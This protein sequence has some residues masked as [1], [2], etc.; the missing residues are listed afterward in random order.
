MSRPPQPGGQGAR[1]AR[2]DTNR[3]REARPFSGAPDVMTGDTTVFCV[4]RG[5]SH[6]PTVCH[7]H[8]SSHNRLP[9]SDDGRVRP[10]LSLSGQVSVGAKHRATPVLCSVVGRSRPRWW[11][12]VF[13]PQRR[14]A[15]AHVAEATSIVAEATTLIIY[16]YT[17]ECHLLA[18][19]TPTRWYFTTALARVEMMRA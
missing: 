11:F 6:T 8:P 4:N 13:V 10:N 14:G 5:V 16:I 3:R 17:S 9:W 1:I 19:T 12:I 7:T 18:L 15:S 2:G